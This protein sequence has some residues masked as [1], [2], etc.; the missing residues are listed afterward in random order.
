[1]RQ[2]SFH[3]A[4]VS[5]AGGGRTWPHRPEGRRGASIMVHRALRPFLTV[6]VN[7]V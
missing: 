4:V 6:W 1:M 5:G 2:N 7:M 3:V